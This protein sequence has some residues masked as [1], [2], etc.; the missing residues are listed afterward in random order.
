MKENL[1]GIGKNKGKHLSLS[2][3]ITGTSYSLAL[4]LCLTRDSLLA[5]FSSFLSV[6][7]SILSIISV[8]II[9]LVMLGSLPAVLKRIPVWSFFGGGIWFADI[10]ISWLVQGNHDNMYFYIII[11][12]FYGAAIFCF[13]YC[14]SDYERFLKWMGIFS[15]AV[16][17]LMYIVVRRSGFGYRD[18]VEQSYSMGYSYIVLPFAVVSLNEL[19]RRRSIL[20]GINSIVGILVLI[21]M[22][23]RGPLLCALSFFIMRVLISVAHIRQ[24]MFLGVMLVGSGTL[25]LYYSSSLLEMLNSFLSL[26]NFSLRVLEAYVEG[27]MLVSNGRLQ[28]IEAAQR[29][30]AEN[31]I[32]G[33][34]IGR[35][36]IM[37]ADYVAERGDVVGFYAHN[38]FYEL[39][40]QFGLVIGTILI[41]CLLAIIIRA[42]ISA[43]KAAKKTGSFAHRDVILIFIAVGLLPLFVSASYL[44]WYLFYILLA[45]CLST[46][47]RDR[48]KR[49]CIQ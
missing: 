22:G 13:F 43:H 7:N 31:F 3:Q 30:I 4:Y 40:L 48:W 14:L 35:E 18:G 42:F 15:L 9:G 47:R 2:P 24:V 21:A 19:I 41:I 17:I 12:F 27:K 20:H 1:I 34:G 29:I 28:I 33:V 16:P 49:K 8:L 25:L 46:L 5:I 11:R 23:T 39:W 10:L 38:I 37:I 6:N 36:R 26:G 32:T 45:V 44:Q